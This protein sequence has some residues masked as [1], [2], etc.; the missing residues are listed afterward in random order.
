M[1]IFHFKSGDISERLTQLDRRIQQRQGVL[2][3]SWANHLEARTIEAFR[4]ETAPDGKKWQKLK[5]E[6]ERQKKRK[7]SP[8]SRNKI[9]QDTGQLYDSVA[10]QVL[11]DGAQLVANR[12]VDGREIGA[13]HQFGIGNLPARPFFPL[14]QQGQLLEGD[15][16]E[17][18]ELAIDWVD[19]LI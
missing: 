11:S 15:K 12:K 17:L 10:A 14:D 18:I 5:P 4:T 13:L 2:F 19:T 8:R 9:L 3:K 7:R 6:T 16:R 1:A